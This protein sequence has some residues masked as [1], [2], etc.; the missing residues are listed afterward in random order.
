MFGV[1]LPKNEQKDLGYEL[2]FKILQNGQNLP[3]NPHLVFVLM[4]V[5]KLNSCRGHGAM[6]L[7]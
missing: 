5:N 6:L 4:F 7:L 3:L 1:S 2:P